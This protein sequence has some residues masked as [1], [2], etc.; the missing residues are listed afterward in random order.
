MKMY[1]YILNVCS[2]ILRAVAP[3]QAQV[4]QVGEDA[5]NAVHDMGYVG[6][7]SNGMPLIS[8]VKCSS[9]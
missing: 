2:S 5:I 9:K 1:F 7:R 6:R 4:A 3:Y 8:F